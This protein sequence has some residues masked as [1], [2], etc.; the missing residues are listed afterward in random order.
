MSIV[1]NEPIDGG[2]GSG[3]V[4]NSSASGFVIGGITP[5]YIVVS[6]ADCNLVK[7]GSTGVWNSYPMNSV[8][9][10]TTNVSSA[11]DNYITMSGYR[12]YAEAIT[13]MDSGTTSTA[14]CSLHVRL[15][16]TGSNYIDMELN[17]HHESATSTGQVNWATLNLSGPIMVGSVRIPADGVLGNSS[18][19]FARAYI[20]NSSS[21]SPFTLRLDYGYRTGGVEYIAG[22]DQTSIAYNGA[23]S[24]APLCETPYVQYKRVHNSGSGN[25]NVSCTIK[26][27]SIR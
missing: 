4:V 17:H 3:S 12:S 16:L 11:F 22:S 23:S 21:A 6:D 19:F 10:V 26:T 20:C 5:S 2:G 7:V 24:N 1:I 25:S 9:A 14:D 13:T 18:E 8:G 15:I 27:V